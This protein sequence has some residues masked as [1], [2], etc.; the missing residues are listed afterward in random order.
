MACKLLQLRQVFSF[1]MREK[2]IIFSSHFYKNRSGI[3][4]AIKFF[5]FTFVWCVLVIAQNL[6]FLKPNSFRY[7]PKK[8]KDFI[9]AYSVIIVTIKSLLARLWFISLPSLSRLIKKQIWIFFS[10]FRFL[11]V[12]WSF[13]SSDLFVFF[14]RYFVSFLFHSPLNWVQ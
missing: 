11:P 9:E 14:R 5:L 8:F 1:R 13:Y 4:N 7:L 2:K 12:Q 3:S 6:G 10:H